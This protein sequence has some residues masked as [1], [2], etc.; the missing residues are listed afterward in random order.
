MRHKRSAWKGAVAGLAGGIAGTLAM[1]AFQSLWN[2][3][4]KKSNRQAPRTE[5]ATVKA[6]RTIA[7]QVLHRRLKDREKDRAG[8]IVHYGFGAMSGAVYGV[9]SEGSPVAR[10]GAGLVFGAGLFVVADEVLVPLLGWSGAPQ[11]YPLASHIYGLASHL[12]YG[13]SAECAR[14][15]VRSRL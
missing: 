2:Q 10:A 15:M 11:E 14:R 4:A 6:A 12:V 13:V 5:P 3:S 8:Q 7:E 1:T 9:L